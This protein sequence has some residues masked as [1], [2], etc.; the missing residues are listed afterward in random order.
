M[1]NPY[2]L[3][4]GQRSDIGR[5]GKDI[6]PTVVVEF[7]SGSIPCS[8]SEPRSVW[9]ANA[10]N[11]NRPIK[12]QRPFIAISSSGVDGPPG[13]LRA[14]CSTIDL[15][16]NSID[17]CDEKMNLIGYILKRMAN[18]AAGP[19]VLGSKPVGFSCSAV[20]DLFWDDFPMGY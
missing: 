11:N 4:G 3:T 2:G 7:E 17:Q 13:L 6:G 19:T 1:R 10:N 5:V 20:L 9:Q 12:G 8:S 16:Y 14:R 18:P 15:S